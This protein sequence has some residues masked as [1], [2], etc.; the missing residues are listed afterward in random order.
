MLDLHFYR[1]HFIAFLLLASFS[2]N[3]Q[4]LTNPNFESWATT[5]SYYT[6]TL[7][8]NWWPFYCNTVK[9]TT[10][11]YQGTYAT[12][13]QGWFA[14]GIAPGVLVNGQAPL[15]YGDF[16]QSGTPFTTKP[17]SISGYYK[18]NDYGTGDSAE[19][20]IILKRYN[21][22][23]MKRDTIAFSTKTLPATS[24]YFLF[25]VNIADLMFG[26]MPDFIII[27]FNF[28]R[29]YLY[30]T[31]IMVLPILYVDRIVMPE[32]PMSILE[33]EDNLLHSIVYP[34]PFSGN[35]TLEIDADIAELENASVQVFD[36]SGKK[37]LDLGGMTS[38][39]I[40][41]QRQELSKGNYFYQVNTENKLIS[42]GKFI[43]Q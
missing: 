32:T 35:A 33:N 31:I 34:N 25:T 2:A 10:D 5:T 24:S 16:I 3:A 17:T 42:Q 13:I 18:Y 15:D 1:I 19:V 21:S 39:K 26:I 41:I 23:L 22:A 4:T 7:P 12:K 6:D 43:I 14:C 40:V 11:S 30:E 36:L 37:V 29:Y 8:S 9:Q 28:S 38:N 27:L 20:T